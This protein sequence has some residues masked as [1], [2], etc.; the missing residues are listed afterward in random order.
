MLH[1]FCGWGTN[2]MASTNS[3]GNSEVANTNSNFVSVA[4]DVGTFMRAYE[5]NFL[6]ISTRPQR[7]TNTR[8]A[9]T[10]TH[11]RNSFKVTSSYDVHS[12]AAWAHSTELV[13]GSDTYLRTKD[14][15][16]DARS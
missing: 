4:G 16:T 7:N 14:A 1:R 9:G 15:T 6:A 12:N 13:R 10:A 5:S 11:T 2:T 3:F 8:T